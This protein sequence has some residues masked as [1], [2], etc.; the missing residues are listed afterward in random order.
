MDRLVYETQIVN[1]VEPVIQAPEAEPDPVICSCMGVKASTIQMAMEVGNASTLDEVNELTQAGTGCRACSCR[2]ERV[3]AGF[4]AQCG[5]CSLC[6]AC[7][8][9]SKLCQCA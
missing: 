1:L 2:I 9:I 7:G 8:V 4:P 6:P 5:P 3:L